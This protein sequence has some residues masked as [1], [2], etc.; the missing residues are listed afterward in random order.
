VAA[1][2]TRCVRSSA[3]PE[4]CRIARCDQFGPHQPFGVY[5]PPSARR[6][7]GAHGNLIPNVAWQRASWFPS[8]PANPAAAARPAPGTQQLLEVWAKIQSGGIARPSPSSDL[9]RRARNRWPPIS[10]NRRRV[11]IGWP[12][13]N[14]YGL[15]VHAPHAPRE[16]PGEPKRRTGTNRRRHCVTRPKC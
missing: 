7:P 4:G 5:R 15:R 8:C 2:G 3:M 16:A 12:M 1:T 14:G 11:S 10:H 6:D 9:D 13:S